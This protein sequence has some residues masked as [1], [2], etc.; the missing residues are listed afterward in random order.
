MAALIPRCV[1]RARPRR[2]RR[3][4]RQCLRARAAGQ[5][6]RRS[7]RGPSAPSRRFLRRSAG[8]CARR[9]AAERLALVRGHPDLAGT[10]RACGRA[11]RAN[12][13]ASSDPPG[14]TACARRKTPSFTVS[15]TPIARKF[16]FPFIIC[17][18][19]H[20]R[21]SILADFARRLA[22]ARRCRARHRARRDRPHRRFAARRAGDGPE[23]ARRRRARS[24]PMCSTRMRG[25]P[26]AGMAVTLR[27]FAALGR[28]AD[29][30]R[31]GHQR[32]RPHRAPLIADRPVPIGRYELALRRATI[33]RGAGSRSS[34]PPFL[35]IV[36]VRFGVA[37]PE[38]HYH[39]PL[40]ADAVELFHISRKLSV[41]RASQAKSPRFARKIVVKD[42]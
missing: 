24:R 32:G 7:R 29:R 30:R 2:L 36:P 38:G 13:W 21:D 27:E 39:V 15:T 6:R 28:G 8:L 25:R 18:R 41:G 22:H 4:S 10:R 40:L 9:A 1:Q 33:S 42:F 23:A 3:P 14:S 19:R 20:T 37:E 16:G 31:G 17:V 26:A 34:D 35:E 5:P 11:H 12:R